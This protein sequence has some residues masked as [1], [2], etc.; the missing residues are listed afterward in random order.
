MLPNWHILPV[1]F[2]TNQRFT[3]EYSDT[4][5][6]VSLPQYQFASHKSGG[7]VTSRFALYFEDVWHCALIYVGPWLVAALRPTGPYMALAFHGEQDS[8]KSSSQKCLKSLVD[9]DKDLLD[10]IPTTAHGLFSTARESHVL[11]FDNLSEIKDGISDALCRLATGGSVSMRKFHTEF[12]RVTIKAVRPVILNGIV[13]VASRADLKRRLLLIDCPGARLKAEAEQKE[14][15]RILAAATEKNAV[16]DAGRRRALITAYRA[17]HPERETETNETIF[18][19]ATKELT[20]KKSVYCHSRANCDL[21]CV[22]Q[23]TSRMQGRI[24]CRRLQARNRTSERGEGVGM[25]DSDRLAPTTR[26]ECGSP[27]ITAI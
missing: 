8:A 25:K 14:T 1:S 6:A 21:R 10:D 23:S 16:E 13:E 11:S 9:P 27:R 4:L 3:V 22:S 7:N 24:E 18:Q 19:L 5:L 26:F 17:K 20:S 2:N 12:G 15:A